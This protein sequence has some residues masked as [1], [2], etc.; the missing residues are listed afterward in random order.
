MR[1]ASGSVTFIAALLFTRDARKLT[2]EE[3]AIIHS[4]THSFAGVLCDDNFCS[5]YIPY[6]SMRNG[7]RQIQK[8]HSLLA[9]D[10]ECDDEDTINLALTEG[11]NS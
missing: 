6:S 8:L 3:K 4:R 1:N 11:H 9:V 10:Y 5:V 2:D 7:C